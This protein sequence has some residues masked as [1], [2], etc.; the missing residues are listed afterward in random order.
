MALR[1]LSLFT[2]V[3]GLDTGLRIACPD[4]RTVCYVESGIE[5]ASVLAA[6]IAEGSIDDAPIWADVRTFDGRAWRGAVDC[7]VGGFPCQDIS[8]AGRGEGIVEG[9]RSGLW[10]QFAQ[11]IREVGPSFVFVENVAALLIRGLDT[12]LAD[13]AALG[14]DAQ[15]I[16][17][18][19]S[20]CGASH[21]RERVFIL[22]YRKHEGSPLARATLT[23]FTAADHVSGCGAGMGESARRGCRVSGESSASDGFFDGSRKALGDT[24]IDYGRREQQE[25]GTPNRWSGFTG[26]GAHVADPGN[27]QL[28]EPRRRS[29]GGNGL[30]PAGE[31]DVADSARHGQPGCG[32]EDRQRAGR[33]ICEAGEP[34]GD[35]DRSRLEERRIAPGERPHGQPEWA[36][37]PPFPPGPGDSAAWREILDVWPYLAPAI[38]AEETKSAFHGVAHGLADLVVL[39]RTDAL[40]QC[41]NGVVPIQAALAFAALAERAMI[42]QRIKLVSTSPLPIPHAKKT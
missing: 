6:R 28:Q 22:A 3:G 13:L 20:D 38:S 14:F 2:G 5:N 8:I 23:S 32:G 9:N 35:A 26:D 25:G 33:G 7:I 29:Q 34:L 42:G 15:W 19:A 27:G 21:R 36:S 18:R 40:R 17:V 24:E 12:V 4:A 10:F 39:E 11:I 16:S 30:G 31:A 41:G 37:L 1:T